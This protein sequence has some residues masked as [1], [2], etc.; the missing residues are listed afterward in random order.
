[1]CRDSGV[2]ALLPNVGEFLPPHPTSLTRGDGKLRV[3]EIF[4]GRRINPDI[5]RGRLTG[6]QVQGFVDQALDTF[7]PQY[8]GVS[9]NLIPF[10]AGGD[11]PE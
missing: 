5:H 11:S 8:V 10:V 6:E 1:M 4:A 9:A 7:P 2:N 3:D